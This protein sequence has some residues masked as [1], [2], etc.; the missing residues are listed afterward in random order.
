VHVR[1]SDRDGDGVVARSRG[2]VDLV[3]V[4]EEHEADGPLVCLEREVPEPRRDLRLLVADPRHADE[5]RVEVAPARGHRDGTL[6]PRRHLGVGPGRD[7]VGADLRLESLP[8]DPAR[9][10]LYRAAGRAAVARVVAA[11]H[12]R[13]LVHDARMQ[14]GGVAPEVVDERHAH[15]VD[16][17]ARVLG[18]AAA[19][20]QPPRV[21]RCPHHAREVL[22]RA[23]R[24]AHRPGRRP[25]LLRGERA[26]DRRRATLAVEADEGGVRRDRTRRHDDVD[27]L[28]LHDLHRGGLRSEGVVHEPDL[29]RSRRHVPK[30][31]HAVFVRGVLDAVDGDGAHAG[32][33][34][35]AF[36]VD[37]DV[38]VHRGRREREVERD[39]D[40]DRDPALRGRRESGSARRLRS[41]RR[42]TAPPRPSLRPV[43]RCRPRSRG[44]AAGRGPLPDRGPGGTARTGTRGSRAGRAEEA[45]PAAWAGSPV[46][47]GGAGSP[48][49]ASATPIEQATANTGTARR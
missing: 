6:L 36:A 47:T 31:E 16:E 33:S 14:H 4:P 20:E 24:I 44:G 35:D 29:V 46:G 8:A 27:A 37:D 3:R 49:W 43:R 10:E 42:G 48:S 19:D 2:C 21:E 28:A 18:I 17:E 40:R 15:A 11:R 32:R 25:N 22:D 12:E 9:L 23:H 45:P 39:L 1:R 13:D 41:P 38:Q 26:L 7:D 30:L 5:E 34:L